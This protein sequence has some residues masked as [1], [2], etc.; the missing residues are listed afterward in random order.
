MTCANAV[1][2]TSLLGY[3]ATPGYTA[4]AASKAYVLLLGEALHAELKPYGIGVTVLCPGPSATS[5]GA[6]AGQND[7]P[8]LRMLMMEPRPVARMGILAMLSRRS[9]VVAGILN[10]LIVFWNR[11]TPRSM[12]RAV[13]QRVLA[14]HGA[15]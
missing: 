4:Y 6:V 9:S 8:V 12:Q 11:L 7:T 5:F 2:D 3:Q 14:A 15:A 10:K 13:M 1:K